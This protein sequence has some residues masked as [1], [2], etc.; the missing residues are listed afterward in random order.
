MYTHCR[1][2]H[3]P[4]KRPEYR[5]RGSGETCGG[6]IRRSRKPARVEYQPGGSEVEVLPGQ[7]PLFELVGAA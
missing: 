3:R 7:L 2:C 1:H 6:R 5:E 4:L